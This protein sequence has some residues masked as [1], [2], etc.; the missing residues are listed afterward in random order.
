M[1]TW[2]DMIISVTSFPN[3]LP[4]LRVHFRRVSLW[5]IALTV[6]KIAWAS[7]AEIGAFCILENVWITWKPLKVLRSCKPCNQLVS[8]LHHFIMEM[9]SHHCLHNITSL[10][11]QLMEITL[12]L[13]I[14]SFMF[15]YL[16]FSLQCSGS[17]C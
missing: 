14:M 4:R 16:F 1:E 17:N 3:A 7:V 12:H 5:L 13:Q 6:K 10:F 9:F 11:T 2:Y 8:Y 15:W